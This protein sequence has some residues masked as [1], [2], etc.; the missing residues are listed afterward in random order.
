M[1]FYMRIV[2]RFSYIVTMIIEVVSDLK[3][4][5]T[6]FG[7]LIVM[8]SL[9]FDIISVNP[10]G[11]YKKVGPFAGGLFTTLRLSLGDFD[12]TVLEE[13]DAKKGALDR[14]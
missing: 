8:A 1:F 6:V 7:I 14:D 3:T 9:I 11:E 13:T 5:L 12:F 10:A 2:E 4:F